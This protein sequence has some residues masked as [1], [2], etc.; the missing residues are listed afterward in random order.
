M[1]S[2]E[3]GRRQPSSGASRRPLPQAG[4]G[5]LIALGVFGAPQGVR[6]ELRV[7]SYT[8]DPKAI[9]AYGPLT[10]GRGARIVLEAVR[11][12]KGDMLAARVAGVATREAAAALTGLELFAR[13][14]QLPPPHEDEF[15]YDDLVGLAATTREGAPLGRVVALSNYGAGDILEIA[16]GA[17][18]E[19]L[20]LP[21]TK[22]VAVEI[23]FAGGR[24]VIQ[25]PHEVEGE[26]PA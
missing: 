7:K 6:G 12:L 16:P 5:K 3:R 11:P 8:G 20:L 25:P 9:A 17:G 2:Q 22:A 18:G 26:T 14:E 4:E 24:I 10:D 13:R 15:Y 23:D 1:A 21:F 19:P